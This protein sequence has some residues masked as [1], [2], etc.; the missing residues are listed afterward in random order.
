M[1]LFWSQKGITPQTSLTKS[2][3]ISH[4]AF[5]KH[6]EKVKNDYK[7]CIF[8][9]LLSKSKMGESK[10]IQ[11]LEKHF[12][13][14]SIPEFKYEFFD[15]NNTCKGQKFE[16]ANSLIYKIQ[17]QMENFNFFVFNILDKNIFMEQE[18]VVRYNF[19]IL[20]SLIKN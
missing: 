15:F 4:S 12:L 9:N 7:R 1:P 16:K 8:I 13:D 11:E 3:E 10:L 2:Y 14:A 18:G 17:N 20:N 5:L 6:L 19:I